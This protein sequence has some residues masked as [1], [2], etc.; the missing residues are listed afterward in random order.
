MTVRCVGG[1]REA[2]DHVNKYGTKHSESIVAED[3]QVAD[4]FC[5]AVDAGG[6]LRERVPPPSRTAASS[7]WAAET[8]ISTQ[9]IHA[10]GP[11]A[12][13]AL[14]SYKYVLH[15]DGQTRA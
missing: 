13:D 6:G 7:G 4:L 10:R 1:V 5:K 11:F 9:K 8:G 2:I 15:G 3:S 14:T 12:L